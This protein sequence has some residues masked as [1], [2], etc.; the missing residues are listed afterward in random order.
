LGILVCRSYFYIDFDRLM[1]ADVIFVQNDGCRAVCSPL[2]P[3]L[4]SHLTRVMQT[5]STSLLAK[6][7][8]LHVTISSTE[9]VMMVLISCCLF[10]DLLQ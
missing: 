1:G 4:P 7:T 6:G 8:L 3:A 5:P 10:T 2:L 9:L